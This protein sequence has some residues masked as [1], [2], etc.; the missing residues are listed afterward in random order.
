MVVAEESLQFGI[1]MHPI[2]G[3]FNYVSMHSELYLGKICLVFMLAC[4]CIKIHCARWKNSVSLE[5]SPRL[6]NYFVDDDSKINLLPQLIL[7][8]CDVETDG[9]LP[10]Y[11]L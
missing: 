2:E 9:K 6:G 4:L 1:G 11:I 5:L 7:V 10:K 8:S 3:S